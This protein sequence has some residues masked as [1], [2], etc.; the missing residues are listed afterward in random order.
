MDHIM[1]RCF[2]RFLVC[3]SLLAEVGACAQ[4]NDA[5]SDGNFN[6]GTVWTGNDALFAV[7][8]DGGN[9]RLRSASPGAA[10]YYL[11]TPST[12]VDDAYWELFFD[13]RFAT[14]GANYV[15]M[16]LMSGAADLSSGVNGYFL[17]IGGTNDRL[18]LFRSDA[19]TATSLGLL[20]SNIVN[21]STSN[22]FRVKVT[23]S[24]AG[25]FTLEYDDGN[26]GIYTNAG[27][28]SDATHTSATHFG[29]R[30]EQSSAASAVNNHFFDDIIA[31]PIPVDN[32]PPELL[33]AT[34]VSA[35]EIDL[36]F[37]E[38]LEQAT[39]EEENNYSI[40]PFNSAASVVL[41]GADPALVH[42]TLA[43]AMQ[44]GNAYTITVNGVEDLAGNACVDEA[45]DVMFVVPD[46]ALPGEVVINEIMADP[47]P[48]VGLPDA[49]FVEIHNTT[50]NKTF[51]LSGWTF[52][53][54]ATTAT[55]PSALLPPGGHA[56]IVD[57]A[58]APLF[59]A[60]PNTIVVATFP[61]L[62]NDGDPLELKSETAVAID[63][64]AYALSWYNDDARDDG[65]WTLERKDPTAPCSSAGNWTAS[66]D[67]Q[68]G[69]PGAQ[70]SVYAIV[71]DNTPPA[72]VSVQVN[73]ASTLVLVFS[74]AMDAASLAS[75]AYTITPLIGVASAVA[76]GSNSA[77]LNLADALTVG[78]LYTITVTNVSDCP[79]NAIAGGNT[80]SFALPEPV[81]AGDVVINEVLYD[82][83][84]TG[85][86]F[87]EIH[88]RSSKTLSLAGWKLGNTSDGAPDDVLTITSASFLLLP[89][90]Y[91]LICE[92]TSNIVSN[93]PKSRTERFVETDLPSYNNGEGG[94]VLQAPDGT[95]LDRF[96]YNDDLHFALVNETEGYSLERI[97]PD[98]PTSDNTNWQ[99]ATYL[100]GKA[101]PGFQNSQYS[102]T[103]NAS[104]EM[105]IDPAIFSPDND[106][107]EDVL[108]IGYRFEQAGFVGTLSVFDIAG[109][110]VRTLM[111]NQLLGTEGAISWNGLLDDGGLGRMGPYIVVFEVFNLEGNTERYKKTVTLAHRLN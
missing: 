14:S 20:T 27:T 38:T 105:S 98:R 103:A 95:Q 32:T 50:T 97:S 86:D 37:S 49:E 47:S 29:L 101:T 70:N 22:P 85:S 93:Y 58:T 87:V 67:P 21:S 76:N 30:I 68:G 46:I 52:T 96:D 9:Q 89:G 2:N 109:R 48:V 42:L 54:G 79:G 6:I 11:S 74:E 23:R 39:A 18:E 34:I 60:F 40:I 10:N 72:L 12:I 77:L 5:F 64:V 100:A 65:G 99:T 81:E 53:D 107:L 62:N 88:N 57:D 84:G 106:G 13:L 33:S 43:I 35:T 19:G 73:D 31:A 4:V 45:L 26:T 92:S 66:N 7:V 94:V 25:L 108:T 61:S 59:S 111:E 75:G 28:V 16:Y 51:N 63:A 83:F 8:D 3:L 69:T 80:A 110:E 1:Q 104:G 82:P 44:N 91:A 78:T 71:P 41:D 55:L 56:I 102:P 17:R 90:G 15:D 36:T 24:I